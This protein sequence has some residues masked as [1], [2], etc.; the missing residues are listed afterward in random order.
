MKDIIARQMQAH[1]EANDDATARNISANSAHSILFTEQT[2]APIQT[3]LD[4]NSGKAIHEQLLRRA[5]AKK[6]TDELD[7]RLDFKRSGIGGGNYKDEAFKQADDDGKKTILGT[8]DAKTDPKTKREK[9]KRDRLINKNRKQRFNATGDVDS[10]N[11]TKKGDDNRQ[12]FN[13]R[14][15][16]FK[17]PTGRNYN[18]YA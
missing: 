7:V 18:P 16:S 12:E 17:E 10:G 9:D 13:S 2:P 5:K 1:Q 4:Q 3:S 8:I 6:L 15:S 11:A 14:R